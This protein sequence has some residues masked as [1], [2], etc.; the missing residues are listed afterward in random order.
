MILY[1]A[2]DI[3]GGKV[4]R[5]SQGDYDA[6]TVYDDDPVAQARDFA[7]QGATWVH[8]VDL[9]GA[10]GGATTCVETVRRIR[11]E[12]GLKV[13]VGGGIRTMEAVESYA[14]A[15]VERIVLGTALVKTPAFA[16]QAAHAF[17]ERIVAG[18]DA[19]DGRVATEGWLE[20]SE[21]SAVQLARHCRELGMRSV[22]YTDIARDG[23]QTGVDAVAYAEFAR[24]T[25][26]DVSASGGIASLDDLAALAR[27]GRVAGVVVG[28]ALYEGNFTV[29]KALRV[30]AEAEQEVH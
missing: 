3:L 24:Q 6:A 20:V 26:M 30:I 8:V 9:E 28:R 27:T 29:S 11:A 18:I 25:G 14:S 15:G 21:V 5:L 2:I 12:S 23:M 4:V 22:V 19:R 17:G 1:P 13:E 16:E 7:A 10:R